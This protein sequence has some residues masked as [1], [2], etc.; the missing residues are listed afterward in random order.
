[1]VRHI[2]DRIVIIVSRTYQGERVIIGGWSRLRAHSRVRKESRKSVWH[3]ARVSRLMTHCSS[4]PDDVRKK[5][6]LV[7]T[8]MHANC[9]RSWDRLGKTSAGHSRSNKHTSCNF[10]RLSSPSN[11]PKRTSCRNSKTSPVPLVG[12]TWRRS[13]QSHHIPFPCRIP[14]V[15]HTRIL[16]YSRGIEAQNTPEPL[17]GC[18]PN[19]EKHS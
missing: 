17:S 8:R 12:S 19:L 6:G 3:G 13:E 18:S 11:Y 5:I 2:F 16:G 14:R 1:V 7:L 10:Y 15:L 9:Y 4:S